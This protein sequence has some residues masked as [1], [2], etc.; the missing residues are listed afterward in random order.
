ML[1]MRLR[2]AEYEV[3]L[4]AYSPERRLADLLGMI[5]PARLLDLWNHTTLRYPLNIPLD[6]RE[7]LN[8]PVIVVVL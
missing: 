4:G 2:P 3:L 6:P 5:L 1:I 7:S 8:P